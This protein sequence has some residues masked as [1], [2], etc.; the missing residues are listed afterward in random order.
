MVY[1]NDEYKFIFIENP[2]SGSTSIIRTLSKSLGVPIS[3]TPFLTNAH[4]TCDQIKEG[5][6]DKWRD[7]LKVTTYRDPIKRFKSS[8]NY[9]R[10]HQLRNIK[11]FDDFKQHLL[12]PGECQYCLPQ[13]EFL[14][15]VDFIINIDTIQ[16]DYNTFCIKVGIPPVQIKTLNKNVKIFYTDEQI[17][18]LL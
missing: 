10:H 4:Q 1:I 6:P 5:F 12:A 2:K 16:E 11:S 14:K 13:S 8:A 15:E 17:N 18:E 3:R 7:Y 9:Y